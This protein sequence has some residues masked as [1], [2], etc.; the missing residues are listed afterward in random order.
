MLCQAEK[1]SRWTQPCQSVV[2]AQLV[3]DAL[4]LAEY[5]ITS[6]QVLGAFSGSRPAFLKA[7]LL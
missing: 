1:L 7:S 4:S 5:C 6:G 2:Y 3:P